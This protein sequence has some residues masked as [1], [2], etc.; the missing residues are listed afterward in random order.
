[1]DGGKNNSDVDATQ[2]LG[3]S[4]SEPALDAARVAERVGVPAKMLHDSF[5]QLQL[6]GATGRGCATT[7]A[8]LR[9]EELASEGSRLHPD[10]CTPCSY[11]CYSLTGCRNGNLC[12]YCH[13]DH[14]KRARRRGRR[15]QGTPTAE[16]AANSKPRPAGSIGTQRG[17]PLLE[18]ATL[19][20]AHCA[21][22]SPSPPA[23]QPLL[24]ALETLAPL[25]SID[26]SLMSAAKALGATVPE[27]LGDLYYIES[28]IRLEVGQ[29]TEVFPFVRHR[30]VKMRFG[31]EPALPSGM[32]L[33]RKSGVIRGRALQLTA[34]GGS[35][36]E[37]SL[38][39]SDGSLR[40][41]STI[42]HIIISAAG[43]STFM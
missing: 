17:E 10:E 30:A 8:A 37:V 34:P 29:C 27:R 16:E 15:Q 12:V 18:Q 7:G 24:L 43:E 2:C 33:D 22:A 6:G 14:P 26:S 9:D 42:I 11:H 3:R 21:A 39:S 28:T 4:S 41:T 23:L 1:V 20:G 13:G 25:P 35:V 38:D 32:H 40:L 31:V 36:H 19:G 5:R